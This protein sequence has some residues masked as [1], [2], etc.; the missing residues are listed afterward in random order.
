MS[1]E[2][3]LA[4]HIFKIAFSKV[5]MPM[6]YGTILHLS[7]PNKTLYTWIGAV[8]RLVWEGGSFC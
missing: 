7:L 6:A 4:D 2:L 1:D 5:S 8:Q 3:P